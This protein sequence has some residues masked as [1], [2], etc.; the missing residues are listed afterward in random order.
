MSLSLWSSPVLS[1]RNR[2]GSLGHVGGSFENLKV[3]ILIPVRVFLPL[4]PLQ[5]KDLT[6][7]PF[8]TQV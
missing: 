2:R 8:L 1:A 4:K 3:A 7:A 6:P 5:A